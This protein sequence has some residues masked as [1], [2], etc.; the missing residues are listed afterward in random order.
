M[1]WTLSL[2]TTIQ[3]LEE[4]PD[5]RYLTFQEAANHQIHPH[6]FRRT[7]ATRLM[8]QGVP[9]EHIMALG[10]WKS[11]VVAKSYMISAGGKE[12]VSQ[13]STSMTAQNRANLR[14]LVF[15]W[16]RSRCRM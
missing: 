9:I 4:V 14:L 10:G 5:N 1:I 15:I 3:R 16:A 8:D 6:Q 11:S 2:S 13:K 12:K 7:Y